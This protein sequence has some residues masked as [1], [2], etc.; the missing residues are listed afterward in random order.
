MNEPSELLR[1]LL[2]ASAQ[3]PIIEADPRS[4]DELMQRVS[5]IFNKP[6]LDLSD[7]DLADTV[8]YFRHQ[9]AK[10]ATL[11]TAEADKPRRSRKLTS[12][13]A[14]GSDDVEL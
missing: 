8:L 11:A 9:R 2:E 10:F 3:T 4:L 14:L 1:R 6:P 12:A 13:A 7:D 5:K